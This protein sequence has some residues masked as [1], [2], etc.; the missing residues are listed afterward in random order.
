[1]RKSSFFVCLSALMFSW[2]NIYSQ[3]IPDGNL[4]AWKQMSGQGKTFFEPQGDYL[5]SLN[6]LAVAI[7]LVTVLNVPITSE[8]TNDAYSG[9]HAAKLTSKNATVPGG[10]VF[11]PGAL[12]NIAEFLILQQTVRL[13]RPY[14]LS[15]KPQRLKGYFKYQPVNN[16]SAMAFVLLSRWNSSNKSRDTIGFG[17]TIIN[18]EINTY[19]LIETPILYRSEI[20]P[21]SLT[22]LV[23]S[24]AGLNFSNLQASVGQE[25]STL[26]VDELSFDFNVGVSEKIVENPLATIFPNPVT[27]IINI[28]LNKFDNHPIEYQIVNLDG[29]IL[30]S[31]IIA[32][33]NIT[34]DLQDFKRGIYVIQLYKEKKLIHSQKILAQ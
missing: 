32:N 18:G 20:L 19:T 10:S 33:P 30:S 22:I 1:M 26:F 11:L 6:R 28:A 27:D 24:S 9:P 34:I 2:V 31:G 21:D 23:C 15:E 13:G 17:K 4:D 14:T 3:S 16:D 12:S 29:K 5:Q 8:R 25:G 7:P